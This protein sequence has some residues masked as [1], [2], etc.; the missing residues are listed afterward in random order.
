V[1]ASLLASRRNRHAVRPALEQRLN[2][3][4]AVAARNNGHS[5]MNQQ[6]AQI[7]IPRLLKPNWRTRLYQ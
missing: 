6:Q 3:W 2:P 7:I 4:R 1:H 5:S